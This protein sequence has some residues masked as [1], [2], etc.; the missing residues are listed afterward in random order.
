MVGMCELGVPAMKVLD[1]RLTV[2]VNK[3][4]NGSLG[5]DNSAGA[6]VM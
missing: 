3:L 6:E 4:P 5:Q 2:T 1:C